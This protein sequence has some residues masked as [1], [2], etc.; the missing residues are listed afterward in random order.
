VRPG[1][2]GEAQ[3]AVLPRVDF[4]IPEMPRNLAGKPIDPAEWNRQDGFSPGSMILTFVPGLDLYK[5][6]GTESM[7]GPR[8]GT[9]NDP[10]DTIADISR[11]L[12]PDAPVV[13]IDATTSQR[14]AFWDELDR[15]SQ[16]PE[17]DRVLIIR[18]A[19]NLAEGHRYVVA[20][21]GLKNAAGLPIPAGPAFGLFKSGLGAPASRQEHYDDDVFPALLAAGVATDESL[22]LAWDFTVASE[23][24]LSSRVL[25]MRDDALALLGDT[26]PGS[27]I[28]GAAPQINVT[29]VTTLTGNAQ[30]RV[31][32]TITVPNYIDRDPTPSCQL[33]GAQYVQPAPIPGNPVSECQAVPGARLSYGADGITSADELPQQNSTVPTFQAPFTCTIPL[34]ASASSRAHPIIYGHGLLGNISE[35]QGG[36]TDRDRERNFMPCATYW[37]G[38]AFYDV[39]NAGLTLLDPSNMA[40]MADRSQQGFVNAI[41]LQRAIRNPA[42]FA[43]LAAFQDSSGSPLFNP[44]ELYYDGNSQGGIMGGALCALSVDL[45]RCV[46]GVVGMNYSTLLN[47]SSDWEV[48]GPYSVPFYAM[49]PNKN[50]Q[51]LVIALIQMLWDRA[52]ADGY[53][54]HMT[55]DP[56]PNTP[57]HQVLLHVAFGDFQV[58]NV[59]AEVEARTIGARFLDTSLPIANQVSGVGRYWAS[60]GVFGL[61]LFDHDSNG[62]VLPWS[63]SALVYW[64][65]GNLPPPNWNVPPA[66]A[67][68]DPHEDPRRDPRAGDQKMDFWLDGLVKDVIAGGPYL[69]CRPSAE[70]QI[71]RVASQFSSD[72]CLPP[73]P[74]P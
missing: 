63:G 45:T 29:K 59:A 1:R 61:T 11:S 40:S 28:D 57:A 13:L 9:A 69:T 6:W 37:M 21:R 36:S 19:V 3:D 31:E 33:D 12:A 70:N 14:W 53:A 71:P 60:S 42:G 5:T 68:G 38:F 30:R 22:Y 52:E 34:A 49:F 73:P 39:A 66:T 47:R 4:Q 10:R 58:T 7:T 23:A 51:Q 41:Y 15:N 67:G 20:V 26:T 48:P 32:G 2:H 44:G 8:V 64:D 27:G 62:A 35:S 16:T 56:L 74:T 24:N 55:T 46:L 72:W 65:S 54:Q 18:P 17:G 43:S 50:E 25:H